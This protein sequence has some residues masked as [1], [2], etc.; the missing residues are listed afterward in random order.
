MINISDSSSS[1]ARPRVEN[2]VLIEPSLLLAHPPFAQHH[3]PPP[4]TPLS[5]SPVLSSREGKKK[6]FILEK[7]FTTLRSPFLVPHTTSHPPNYYLLSKLTRIHVVLFIFVTHSVDCDYH[8]IQMYYT[9]CLI[10][11]KFFVFS[12]SPS[13]SKLLHSNLLKQSGDLL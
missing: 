9:S 7:T 10:K 8:C 1:G 3:H 6:K 5:I 4:P 11:W 12:V 13:F 2:L